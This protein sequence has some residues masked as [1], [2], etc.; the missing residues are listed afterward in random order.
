M[1]ENE[2]EIIILVI[3]I[4][5]SLF[6]LFVGCCCWGMAKALNEEL[7][8]YGQEKEK[9]HRRKLR[10]KLSESGKRK[11]MCILKKGKV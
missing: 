5:A 1:G 4:M 9:Q 8:C 10:D 3:V 11:K 6:M 7:K 2:M